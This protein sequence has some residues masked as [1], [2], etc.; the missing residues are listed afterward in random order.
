MNNKLFQE[1][2]SNCNIEPVLSIDESNF[3]THQK[4]KLNRH[5]PAATN[6]WRNST[7]TYGKNIM[8][9]PVVDNSTYDL[10]K[11][12]FNSTPKDSRV[13]KLF[14]RMSILKIFISRPKVKNSIN[15]TAITILSY[16]R[17]KIYFLHLFQ[18]SFQ[19]FKNIAHKQKKTPLTK[20]NNIKKEFL[21]KDKILPST[22]HTP[23]VNKLKSNISPAFY[24]RK[25]LNLSVKQIRN[26]TSSHSPLK[27]NNT[28]SKITSKRINSIKV[29]QTSLISKTKSNQLLSKIS[30]KYLHLPNK[31]VPI[32][33]ENPTTNNKNNYTRNRRI[34]Y[35]MQRKL[36][37]RVKKAQKR[38]LFNILRKK[39]LNIVFSSLK[40][41]FYNKSSLF[42]LRKME[43]YTM[44]L[45]P[46]LGNI[47]MFI[48][49]L[50][51]KKD[52]ITFQFT[53]TYLFT[54]WK[55]YIDISSISPFILKNAK[56]TQSNLSQSN[57]NFYNDVFPSLSFG[58]WISKRIKKVLLFK[59]YYSML[60]FYDVKYNNKH[61]LPLKDITK[62]RYGKKIRLN[63]I[64]LKYLYLDSNIL[65][66]AITTKLKDR[67]KRVLRVL[68]RT[69][70][71]IKKPYFK[72]HFYNKKITLEQ[73]LNAHILLLDKKFNINVNSIDNDIIKNKDLFTNP[74]NYKSRLL[75][76]HLKHKIVSG[77][78]IEGSGRL[79]RRLTASRSISKYKYMGS[80]QNLNSSREGISTVMLRGYMKSNLQY[81]NINNNNR[82][83][84]FGV[85]VSVSC[86]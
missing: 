47:K 17:Q 11:L 58:K 25:T 23:T 19:L 6:E 14:K 69:L 56:L 1:K 74:S 21:I 81:I 40:H 24:P 55:K 26:Y 85:K 64:N 35:W 76:Y 28:S 70:G 73:H 77:V 42:V 63:I 51:N 53:P 16:N 78:R 30:S 54:I 57:L 45:I 9:S 60:Y 43:K 72:I 5:Y 13:S 59:Y 8:I 34:S 4:T 67:K 39:S 79:T 75:L 10:F 62:K 82:N 44:G 33:F 22:S 37:K 15:K 52:V 32:Y 27:K 86:Y 49:N 7:Y 50:Y 46:L 65:A 48:F 12:Y 2:L 31:R 38:I 68:K 80:L 83:G 61:L 18:K 66:E 84:A 29:I 71:L 41:Y 20:N 36:K 3:N